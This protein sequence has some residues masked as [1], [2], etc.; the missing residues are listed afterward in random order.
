MTNGL[1]D[2]I[3]HARALYQQG[4]LAEAGTVCDTVLRSQPNNFD[5]LHLAGVVALQ[6]G[7]AEQGVAL[8]GKAVRLRGREVPEEPGHLFVRVRAEQGQALGPGLSLVAGAVGVHGAAVQ[9]HDAPDQRE[10]NAQSSQGMLD[11]C[12]DLIEGLEDT[13]LLVQGNA[14]SNIANTCHSPS[15][16][17]LDADVDATG[18]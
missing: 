3:R 13:R 10:S 16:V 9:L 18:N 12:V 7:Q 14:N 1:Q 15:P 6:T 5:A 4:M 2:Q 11:R 8:I 17:A